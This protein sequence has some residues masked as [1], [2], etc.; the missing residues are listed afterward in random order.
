M[1]QPFTTLPRRT[2]LGAG[3]GAGAAALALPA[4]DCAHA[5]EPA[6]LE[7]VATFTSPR[8]VTGVAASPDGRVFVNFP[9]WEE[10]VAI[11]VAEVGRNGALT[12][13][14]NAAWN[15]FRAASPATPE[16]RFVC[17]QS[18]TCDP[19]GNLWIVD[20]A[21]PNLGLE[22]KGGP[23][24]ARIDLRRNEVAQ[25]YAFDRSVAPQGSYLNDIRFTPDG[26]RAV[27]TN[28]GQ[29]GCLIVLDVRSGQ[30]RRVLDGHPS[31]QFQPGVV[32]TVGGRALRRA[33]GETAQ[34]SADGIAIDAHGEYAYWQ[35]TTGKTMYRAPLARL[36]DPRLTPAQQ[37][38]AVETVAQT[39]IADGYWM[40][41]RGT[42]LLTSCSDNS[43]KRMLPDKTFAVVARDPRL[44]WPDSMA[45]GPD[46][47][48]YVT[49]SH[50]P[51]MKAWQGA[52]VKQSQLFRFKPA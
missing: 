42:L 6:R 37:G 44:L 21:A 33:D 22:V 27:L 4:L 2:L 49:A 45:E 23:K 47:V 19:Q 36:F 40:S 32:V 30:A 39:F 48:I 9:R 10:D 5:A 35:A 1:P 17:V 29:P 46:G 20:A 50:I 16:Q 43:V 12:P 7:H 26:Q 51:E 52:G 8:Q 34:F 38:D 28:S 13:Y 24:L 3:L 15:S 14:P 31:T 11:S 18:V 41:G 25:V